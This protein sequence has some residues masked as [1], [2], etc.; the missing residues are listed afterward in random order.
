MSDETWNI[1]YIYEVWLYNQVFTIRDPESSQSYI[2]VCS[3]LHETKFNDRIPNDDNRTAEG[4]ELRDEFVATLSAIE[5]GDYAKL[6]DLGKASL[7]EML[8]AF[9]RRAND[10]I[11]LGVPGWF[12]VFLENLGLMIFP[13]KECG[14]SEKLRIKRIISIMNNRR[15]T[16]SGRGGLFPLRN[17]R[18]DQRRTELWYQMSAYMSENNMY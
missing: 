12:R 7:L 2:T 16:S 9:A 13:D 11:G 6:H 18:T 1:R 15:Y 3:M 8:I 10:Q 14:V 5:V 4:M 17:P